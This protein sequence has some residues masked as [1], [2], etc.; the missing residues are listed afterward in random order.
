MDN[1]FKR[2][3]LVF[4]AIV[5]FLVILVRYTSLFKYLGIVG[6]IASLLGAVFY[7]YGDLRAEATILKFQFGNITKDEWKRHYSPYP[8][9]KRFALRLAR[10]VGS[11][12]MTDSQQYLVD[13]FPMKFWGVSLILLGASFQIIGIFIK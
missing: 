4:L 7:I 6:I 12:D 1:S 8:W 9:W 10:L 3:A 13:S 5:V 11:K 2:M